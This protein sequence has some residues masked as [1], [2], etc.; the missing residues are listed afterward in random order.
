MRVPIF[1]WIISIEK[2]T[3]NKKSPTSSWTVCY[4]RWSIFRQTGDFNLFILIWYKLLPCISQIIK[5]NFMEIH[6]LARWSKTKCIIVQLLFFAELLLSFFA[7]I[8]IRYKW[9]D[10]INISL[11]SCFSVSF[12][13]YS[14]LYHTMDF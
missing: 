3:N 1:I 13:K 12:I 7:T 11:N 2:I 9:N 8:I 14:W 4:N 10:C 6:R 5:I